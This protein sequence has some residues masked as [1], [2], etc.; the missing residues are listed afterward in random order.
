MLMLGHYYISMKK[1]KTIIVIFIISLSFVFGACKVFASSIIGNPLQT[2][3]YLSVGTSDTNAKVNVYSTG[4]QMRLGY[5]SDNYNSFTTDSFGN[6]TIAPSSGGIWKVFNDPISPYYVAGYSGNAIIGD[7]KWGSA[8]LSGGHANDGAFGPNTIN[9]NVLSVI[10]GGEGNKIDWSGPSASG[11]ANFIGGGAGNIIEKNP[12]YS[13]IVGGLN[14]KVT[15]STNDGPFAD[16]I[17][18]GEDNIID[19]HT[20][21]HNFIGGGKS[22]RIYGAGYAAIVGGLSNTAWTYSFVGGGSGNTAGG[23]SASYAIVGGGQNN[24]ATADYSMVLGG[25]SNT[26]SGQYSFASGRRAKAIHDGAFIWADSNDFD[27]SSTIAN[28]T[29][30]RATGGISFVTAIDGSGSATKTFS[31]DTSGNFTIPG[32]LALQTTDAKPTC[33]V[34]NRGLKW[35]TQSGA[36]VKDALEICAKDAGDTYAWRTI[37]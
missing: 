14:N 28:E 8:I 36:G 32:G 5:D 6:F 19:S 9:N 30:I 15:S 33:D 20:G 2:D 26:A 18:G 34:T 24:S 13:V 35:Y 25:L 29:A 11:S 16:F 23:T 3:G 37:Y 17:G 4:E 31:V 22:N 27:F 1:I 10:V 21:S 7:N 12:F